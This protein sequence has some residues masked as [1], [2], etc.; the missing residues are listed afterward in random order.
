MRQRRKFDVI[1]LLENVV[2][3]VEID[4]TRRPVTMVSNAWRNASGS[5]DAARLKRP[6]HHRAENLRKVGL[7]VRI[8][9]LKRSAIRPE[10]SA[11]SP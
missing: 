8:K 9:L 5:V 11:H 6:L 7:I 1:L 3:D 2:G 4:R 10:T